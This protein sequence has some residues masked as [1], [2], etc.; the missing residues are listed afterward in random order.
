MVNTYSTNLP[1][2]QPVPKLSNNVFDLFSLKG[3]VAVV[4]GA[5]S[6][7][8]YA[9]SEA[10]AQAGASLALWY[11]SNTELVEKA[12]IMAEKYNVKVITYKCPVTEEPKVKETVEQVVK[13]FG[14]IDIFIANAGVAWT[15]G[16]LINA[17]EQGVDE[18]EWKKVMHTDFDGVYYCAKHVGPQFKKQGNG[19]MVITASMSGHIV[20]VPQFQACYNAAKAGVL[21]YAKSLAIEWTPFA[22]VN[23]V[24]PGYVETPITVFANQELKDHWRRLTP[25]GREGVPQELVGAYLYFASDAS[26]FTTGSDLIVDGGYCAV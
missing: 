17:T 5:S 10:F 25:M 16:S 7:I 6:G 3:K 18:S 15:K 20:N 13:D 24:S 21:H 4:T 26:T 23:T 14:K 9:V 22:R 12:K 11:N 19:S 8:G 2:P 1:I